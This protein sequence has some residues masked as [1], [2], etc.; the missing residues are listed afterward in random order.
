MVTAVYNFNFTYTLMICKII[1]R[2][3]WYNELAGTS[4]FNYTRHINNT[5]FDGYENIFQF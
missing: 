1:H 4:T 5:Y 2:H 3:N